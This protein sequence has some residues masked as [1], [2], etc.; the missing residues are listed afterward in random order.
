MT[1]KTRIAL[2]LILLIV[3]VSGCKGSKTVVSNGAVNTGLTTKQLIRNSTKANIEFTTLVS[4]LKIETT[5]KGSSKSYTVNLKIE[6]DKQ[7]L[8][9]STPISIIKA[10]ITPDRVAFYNK[11]DNTFFDGDFAYLSNLLGTDLDFKKVQNLLLGESLFDL[12]DDKYE[13]TANDKSYILQPKK[14]RDLFE[15]LLFVNPSH[16]KMDAQEITQ[17]KEKRILHI[18][19]LTYQQVDKK[20]LPEQTK[21]LAVEDEEELEINLELK[22]VKLNENIRFAFKIP[23]GFTKIEL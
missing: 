17:P 14:Q 19:Y 22:S 20:T 13:L 21:I 23:T 3:V 16:Y 1:F 10:I 12:N 8:I 18:D 11:W 5:Q 9:T 2:I 4:R 6:K 15:L 7:I